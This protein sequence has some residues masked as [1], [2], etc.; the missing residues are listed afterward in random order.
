MAR[1]QG[2]TRASPRRRLPAPP[3]RRAV[4]RRDS[5]RKERGAYPV[6]LADLRPAYVKTI[7]KD[8]FTD[9]ALIYKPQAKGYLL[10]SLGENLKD[11]GGVNDREQKDDVAVRVKQ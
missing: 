4:E 1:A 5:Y 10:Y 7:P 8:V 6:K 9:K 2:R 11:D 3:V